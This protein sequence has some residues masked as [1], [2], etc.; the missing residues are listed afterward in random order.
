MNDYR[1][2]NRSKREMRPHVVAVSGSRREGSY[3][4]R[5]LEEALSGVEAVDGTTELLDLAA[6][7]LP[8][9]DPGDGGAGDGEVVRRPIR[10]ADAII[11]GTPMYHGS[12]SGALKNALDYGGFDEFEHA[13]V[14]LLAV[15]GGPFP[16]AALDHLQVVCRSLHAWVHPYRAAVPQ[17][18]TVF[19]DD[20]LADEEVRARVR[21][22]GTQA[23]EY[24]R[25]DP[26]R[27]RTAPCEGV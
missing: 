3:T 10:E 21:E 20:G 2:N 6:L 8:T 15:S 9:F 18:H 24:A 4:R 13:T 19:D 12:Y 25:I 16:T 27:V 26:V 17:A 23:V 14:G 5:A 11:L 7:D 22:L 1:Q